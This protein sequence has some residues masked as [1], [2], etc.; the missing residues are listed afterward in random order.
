MAVTAEST[1]RR[2]PI[3][4]GARSRPVVLLFGARA[5]NSYVDLSSDEV[6]AHFGFFRIRIPLSNI[7]R[8]T[9]EGPWM[10]IKAIGVR[11]GI[12]DG[13]ISFDGNH[14]GGVRLDFRTPQRWSIVSVPRFYVTVGNLEGFASALAERGIPGEDVRRIQ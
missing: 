8:W 5:A 11:R 7:A 13:A 6:D 9:I 12:R 2:F 10:W 14:E 3:R 1:T 4:I